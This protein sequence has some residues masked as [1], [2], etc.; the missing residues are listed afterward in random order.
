LYDFQV[1]HPKTQNV[2]R[3]YR[4]ISFL[5]KN[6]PLTEKF[7]TFATKGFTGT[8]IYV[9]K[10]GF[11]EIGKAKVTKLVRGVFITKRVSFRPLSLGLLERSR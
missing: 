6:D 9:F 5:E 1:I 2:R 4:K 8:W 11:A 7:Q 3:I 10:P